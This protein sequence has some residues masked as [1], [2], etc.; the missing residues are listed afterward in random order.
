[1]RHPALAYSVQ[2]RPTNDQRPILTTLSG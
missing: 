2:Y 1:M